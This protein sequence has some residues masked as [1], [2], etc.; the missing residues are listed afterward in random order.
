MK[1]R[2]FKKTREE[3]F[4]ALTKAIETSPDRAA[5]FD[6]FYEYTE[7]RSG[8]QLNDLRKIGFARHVLDAIDSAMDNDGYIPIGA[9]EEV[10]ESNG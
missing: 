6:A 7:N 8:R 4:A 9:L 10:E 2:D 1:D 3:F 5:L